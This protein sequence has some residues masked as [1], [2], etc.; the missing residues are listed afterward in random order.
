MLIGVSQLLMPYIYIYT[1][2]V[3][4]Y[5]TYVYIYVYIYV[6]VMYM[7]I[8]GIHGF[9]GISRINV[10]RYH[11]PIDGGA[12]FWFLTYMTCYDPMNAHQP[13]I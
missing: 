9:H 1:F 11:I 10:N 5:I 7:Y 2:I 13:I 6:Y 12:P 4:I 8:V 3:Y